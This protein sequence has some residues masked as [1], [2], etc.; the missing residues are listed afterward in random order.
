MTI[1]APATKLASFTIRRACESDVRDLMWM[2]RELAQYETS[3]TSLKPRKDPLG[4]GSSACIPR[5]PR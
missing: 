5:R 4:T 1:Q 2:I 3:N